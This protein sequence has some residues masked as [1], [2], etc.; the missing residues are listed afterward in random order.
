MIY[1]F[2]LSRVFMYKWTVNWRLVDEETFLSRGWAK[3]LIIGQLSTLAA[4]GLFQW[5]NRDGGVWK[6]LSRGLR[7]PTLPAGLAPITADRELARCDC[8]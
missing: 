6:V 1:A 2:D 5:C 3:G 4:F 7:R 8:V